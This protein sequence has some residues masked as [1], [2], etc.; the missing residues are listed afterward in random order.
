MDFVGAR[1]ANGRLF[2]TLTGLDLATRESLTLIADRSLT[3]VKVDHRRQWR[4]VCQ[5]GDGCLG[6]RT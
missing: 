1:L 5:S 4:R 2:R 3:W 6:V